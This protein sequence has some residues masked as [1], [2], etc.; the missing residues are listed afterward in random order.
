M[1]R[2]SVGGARPGANRG[3]KDGAACGH[4]GRSGVPG[5]ASSRSSARPLR[6][7][8]STDDYFY[9]VGI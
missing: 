3:C 6:T 9:Q 4:K 2:P 5:P 8:T 1:V 7:P